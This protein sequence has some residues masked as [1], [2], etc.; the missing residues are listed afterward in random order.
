M[1]AELER[2][3]ARVEA[4]VLT[5]AQIVTGLE[6]RLRDCQAARSASE[7]AAAAA[8]QAVHQASCVLF[9]L[10]GS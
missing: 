9:I 10:S 8:H 7:A 5:T 3:R 1:A 2:E 6:A 4:E